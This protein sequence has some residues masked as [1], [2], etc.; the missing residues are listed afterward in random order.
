M[1][2]RPQHGVDHG[3]VV[4]LASI[5]HEA[6]ARVRGVPCSTLGLQEPAPVCLHIDQVAFHAFRQHGSG[7]LL[8]VDARNVAQ[9]V[10]YSSQHGYTILELP[11]RQRRD[12]AAQ[13][14]F[15]VGLAWVLQDD[16]LLPQWLGVVQRLR[17]LQGLRVVL[18]LLEPIECL[19]DLLEGCESLA[20]DRR[21]TELLD[22]RLETEPVDLNR[23]ARRLARF[24][25]RREIAPE[26]LRCDNLRVAASPGRHRAEDEWSER[27]RVHHAL[28]IHRLL[29]GGADGAGANLVVHVCADVH[30]LALRDL[31]F[32][33][34]VS[35]V[36]P[37][38]HV[39]IGS[40]GL[41]SVR[42]CQHRSVQVARLVLQLT[43]RLVGTLARRVTDLL[44]AARLAL[45]HRDCGWGE[46]RSSWVYVV[47]RVTSLGLGGG[48]ALDC[49]HDDVGPRVALADPGRFDYR[50]LNKH[51]TEDPLLP[52]GSASGTV[53]LV[54][55]VVIRGRLG[56]AL[57]CERG[58]GGAGMLTRARHLY[59]SPTKVSLG[60]PLG[61]ARGAKPDPADRVSRIC[62]S[63]LL[64]SLRAHQTHGAQVGV[65]E[66]LALLRP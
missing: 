65:A 42:A 35:I 48:A 60:A 66:D 15:V 16:C 62:M 33:L 43:R 61:A 30:H 59:A 41:S 17:V 36:L 10:I 19:L 58:P 2:E 52:V 24:Q 27:V 1:V 40:V 12:F 18:R 3:R 28:L 55:P 23:P 4:R 63:V 7:P 20:L 21:E 44:H 13:A 51:V 50:W 14:R 6:V 39:Q 57:A 9:V 45:V 29:L 31:R 8:L 37:L 25:S 38:G 5:L 54:M 34:L 46:H 11:L 22:A 47:A 49:A 56:S 64:R 32:L 53:A 26:S